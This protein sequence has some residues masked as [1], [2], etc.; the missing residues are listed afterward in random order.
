MPYDDILAQ[1]PA[2]L[3]GNAE[4]ADSREPFRVARQ[5]QSTG[6]RYKL[7]PT[8]A[9]AQITSFVATKRR[10]QVDVPAIEPGTIYA[11]I[12]RIGEIR[13]LVVQPAAFDQPLVGSLRHVSVDFKV[14][15]SR[16]ATDVA[17]SI[18]EGTVVYYT[19]LSY[20][21]SSSL[22]P[23]TSLILADCV[24]CPQWGAPV[25]ACSITINNRL[26]MITKSLDVAIRFLRHDKES[27]VVWIDQICINQNDPAEKASQVQLMSLIYQRAW[28]TVIWLSD[29]PADDAFNA[30]YTIEC[31][32][33]DIYHP[34]LPSE[35]ERLCNPPYIEA[36]AFEAVERLFACP[37]F[38]RTWTIQEA[39]LS[40]DPWVMSGASVR[41]WDN[42]VGCCAGLRDLGLFQSGVAM[43]GLDNTVT[44]LS[45]VPPTI[46]HGSQAALTIWRMKNEYNRS[47]A[48]MSLLTALVETR[49][50]QAT[51]S[52]DNIYGVLGVCEH[53]VFPDYT[54][55][56]TL[57]FRRV[58]LQILRIQIQ[59][60]E[61]M[62]RRSITHTVSASLGPFTLLY[63]IDQPANELD[64][65]ESPSWVV[66]WSKPRV[67]AGLVSNSSV[68]NCFNAGD[69]PSITCP[70]QISDDESMLYL[71]AKLFDAIEHLG[72]I[73][74]DS[75]LQASHSTGSIAF[76]ISV[77]YAISPPSILKTKLSFLAF[78][79]LLTAGKDITGREKYS[80]AYTEIIS[81]LC[82]TITRQCPTFPDQIY[83]PRQ[84]KGRLTTDSLNTRTCGRTFQDFMKAF[85]SA[86][87]NRRLC[88]NKKGHLGLVPRFARKDDCVVVVPGCPVPFVIRHAGEQA[89]VSVH[90]FVGESYVD[91]IMHGE[92]MADSELELSDVCL[93]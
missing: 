20:V 21:V 3:S 92:V 46:S 93:V 73:I 88:W 53:D 27:I 7:D 78:C 47:R 57:L 52:L 50:T 83:T 13:V 59:D 5:F 4:D 49:H 24:L 28:N 64:R 31:M 71:S 45:D 38:Q 35:K 76:R 16:R 26:L 75:D 67:T 90:Q 15:G 81:F 12:A 8:T 1:Y 63:C 43:R 79:K 56:P 44:A 40:N 17:V 6:G 69:R 9:T 87:R 62:F 32:T 77:A 14:E 85:A 65:G 41:H 23:S 33:Q 18:E 51:N 91:G 29:T 86:V 48:T 55:Q 58:A 10:D 2:K 84:Q 89:G 66:D 11:P 22:G 39:V 60:F 36:G 54:I 42:S 80:S 72:P 68:F 70:L 25:L 30:I 19:A 34:L 82:D 61:R 37:W 74:R